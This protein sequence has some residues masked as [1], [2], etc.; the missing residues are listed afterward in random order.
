VALVAVADMLDLMLAD[1]ER[2]VKVERERVDT[3]QVAVVAVAPVPAMPVVEQEVLV[4]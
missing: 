1:Q 4:G 3:T 2:L